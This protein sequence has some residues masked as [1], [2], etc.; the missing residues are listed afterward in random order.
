MHYFCSINE[1]FF[2]FVVLMKHM[3]QDARKCS[4]HLRT[5]VWWYLKKVLLKDTYSS[6]F[7][8]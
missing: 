8:A 5:W 7:L 4:Y 3:K 2:V 6:P 1:M